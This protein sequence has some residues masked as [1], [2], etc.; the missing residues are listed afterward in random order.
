MFY[1]C[2]AEPEFVN[3]GAFGAVCHRKLRLSN[4][5]IDVATKSRAPTACAAYLGQQRSAAEILTL[6][7]VATKSHVNI[8]SF[9][10]YAISD[11]GIRFK[12]DLF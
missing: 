8:V 7:L 11:E 3:N 2:A 6:C 1:L 9:F 10:G 5:D 4:G 12:S